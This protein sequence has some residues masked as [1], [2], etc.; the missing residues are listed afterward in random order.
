MSASGV[1]FGMAMR[2]FTAYP[3]M[4]DPGE[5]VAFAKRAEELG[6]ES[7]WVWDHVF[8]GVE[9]CFPILESLTLLTAVACHT[10]RIKLGTGV[11]V[12]PLRNP[13]VLAKTAATLDIISGGR[14][15]LG[16]AS[17][18]Y[19]RE[20]NAVGIDFKKRGKI[21]ERNLEIL[22]RLWTEDK[23]DGEY[24]P[25]R[26]SG[27][28][29]QPKPVQRPRPPILIGGYVD[30]VLKRAATKADGWLTYFYTP[31]GF[32][33]SWEKIERFAREAGKDPGELDSLNQLPIMV[34]DHLSRDKERMEKWLTTEWDYAAWS[35]STR[36]SAIC[37]PVGHCVEQLRRHVEVGV[38]RIVLVPYQYRPDQVERLAVEVIPQLTG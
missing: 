33:R 22:T 14:L 19:A 3:A 1:K 21:F 24:P 37:G 18:W 28:V 2:N 27:A 5:L 7:V 13:A 29:L 25:H 36:E 31:E 30:A 6:Y 8:L 4:P 26:L 15:V 12:L 23:V 34:T 32:A 10:S 16:M 11:L 20:F 38:K 35:E 9:P 17:G